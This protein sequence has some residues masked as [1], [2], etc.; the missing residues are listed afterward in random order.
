MDFLAIAKQGVDFV[1]MEFG[2]GLSRAIAMWALL[3]VGIFALYRSGLLA[4]QDKATKAWQSAAEGEEAA[5]EAREVETQTTINILTK[6]REDAE[7]SLDKKD[8]EWEARLTTA[9]NAVREEFHQEISAL[10]R[11]LQIFGCKKAP[12]C[13]NVE[14]IDDEE[15]P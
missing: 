7:R 1:I 15:K 3:C 4:A 14:Q 5:R 2:S 13:K 8:K 10:K 9:V 11:R 12:T 6:A